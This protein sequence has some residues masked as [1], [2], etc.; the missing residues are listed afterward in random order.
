MWIFALREV[1]EPVWA[2]SISWERPASIFTA[3]AE[4]HGKRKALVPSCVL[5][6]GAPSDMSFVSVTQMEG[7]IR[8]FTKKPFYSRKWHFLHIIKNNYIRTWYW[9]LLLNW[10]FVK[11]K[12]KRFLFSDIDFAFVLRH[13][14]HVQKDNI[15]CV[16]MLCKIK[17]KKTVLFVLLWTQP[18]KVIYKSFEIPHN[19]SVFQILWDGT[20]GPV[21]LQFTDILSVNDVIMLEP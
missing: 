2:R 7:N 19:A 10:Y 20:V 1:R 5:L 17:N 16:L 18:W 9:D 8:Y 13:K 3:H 11:K 14:K 4:H 6:P 21:Y 12:S 15:C